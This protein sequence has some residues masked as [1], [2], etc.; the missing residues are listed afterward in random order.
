[1]DSVEDIGLLDCLKEVGLVEGDVNKGLFNGEGLLEVEGNDTLS[2]L[3][4][5]KHGCGGRPL[6]FMTSGRT[7]AMFSSS[8]IS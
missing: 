1:L 8:L 2:S 4:E 5:R 6:D 7:T 3:V